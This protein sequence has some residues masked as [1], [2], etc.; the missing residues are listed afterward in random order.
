MALYQGQWSVSAPCR[1]GII[2]SRF[3]QR[4]S[5]A[6]LQG[7]IETLMRLGMKQDD[8]DVIWVP[9]AFEVPG[10]ACRV[11]TSYDAVITLG[12]IIRGETP[13]FDYVAST[14]AQG[15]A[16]LAHNGATPVI[17]GILTCNTTEEAE[18]RSGGKSGN[19]GSDAAL[20]AI[21]MITL[22]RQLSGA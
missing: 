5:D 9:G 20:T 19:K 11:L 6:L 2:I 12:A 16:Q 21:E 14:T 10:T 3:N 1:I 13:H 4:I 18:A 17:F 15:V 22:Y 8:I 7:A